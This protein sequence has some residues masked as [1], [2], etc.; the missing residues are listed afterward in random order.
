MLTR[1]NHVAIVVPDLE[2]AKNKYKDVLNA[3]VS[4]INNYE[5]HGVSVVFVNVGN[6]KIE[7]MYPYGEK[8]PIKN[9]L[10]KNMNGAIHHICLEVKDIYK[11]AEELKR[12]NIRILG[13]GSPKNGAHNKPVLFLHPKDFFGTLIELEQE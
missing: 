10:D 12:K 13:D 1:F 4:E 6:T 11:T 8:S 2:E 5:E 3:N 7:L 9:F